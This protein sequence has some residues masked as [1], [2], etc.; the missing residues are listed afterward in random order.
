MYFRLEQ[1]EIDDTTANLRARALRDLHPI[2]AH[3]KESYVFGRRP[4]VY[5]GPIGGSASLC[6]AMCGF[7]TKADADFSV[8]TV[9]LV[10]AFFSL[11]LLVVIYALQNG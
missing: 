6:D 11:L 3:M 2:A 7:P 8:Q 10:T 1:E 4:N 9:W 5:R